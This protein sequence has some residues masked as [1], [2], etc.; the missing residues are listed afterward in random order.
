MQLA[1][2]IASQAAAA[3]QKLYGFTADAHPELQPTRKEFE[4]DLTLVVFPYLRA[5][6]KKPVSQVSQGET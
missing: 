4:G 2:T 5:S 6:R 1:Q 3:L